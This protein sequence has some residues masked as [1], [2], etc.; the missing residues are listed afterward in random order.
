[1]GR[2]TSPWNALPAEA[3]AKTLNEI[4]AAMDRTDVGERSNEGFS[5]QGWR[6]EPKWDAE[7][8]PCISAAAIAFT[9]SRA[10]EPCLTNRY[11]EITTASVDRRSCSFITDGEIVTFQEDIT[12]SL[13]KLQERMQVAHPSAVYSVEVP[14]WLYL[15]DL[16]R[17]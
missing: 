14:V 3:R 13:A 15:F 7:P 10:I 11:P 16:A 9:S 5:G 1:M 17:P 8:M 2:Y 4:R 12:R 6:I